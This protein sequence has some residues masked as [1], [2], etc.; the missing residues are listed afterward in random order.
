[1]NGIGEARHADFGITGAKDA[2]MIFSKGEPLKKVAT[3][4]LVDELFA[5]IDKFYAAGKK[6]VVDERDAAEA[7][8]WLAANEDADAMT[9]ERLAA[10]E[11]AKA[12]AAE[13]ITA[14]GVDEADSPVAGRRFS[15]A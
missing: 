4:H 6:V 10:L 1:V 5:E 9:P 11:A 15:R 13:D 8:A 14:P 2:G 7:A 3:E 12:Q